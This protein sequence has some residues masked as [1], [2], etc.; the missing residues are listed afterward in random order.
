[1][2]KR[3]PGAL[4]LEIYCDGG[5]RGNPGHSAYGF[6]VLENGKIIEK[7]GG[8]IGIATNNFAE[9]TAI[10]KALQWLSEN[11]K[12]R[13][14]SFFLDSELAF[15]Q[16]SGIYK[17]KNADIRDFIFKIRQLENDFPAVTYAHVRREK[18]KQA[19]AMVNLALDARLK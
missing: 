12:G 8:Y 13:R 14:L 18:N 5:S 1:M 7:Q 19:D 9:Y 16:L 10:V 4:P 3:E 6:V 11:Q 2:S 17:V 15:S